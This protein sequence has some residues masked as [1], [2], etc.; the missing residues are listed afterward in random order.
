MPSA[1]TENGGPSF[2][3][4]NEYVRSRGGSL[5]HFLRSLLTVPAYWIVIASNVA[6]FFLPGMNLKEKATTLIWI[7]LGQSIMIGIVH[8][9][10]LFTYRF[11]PFTGKPGEWSSPKALGAF[12]LA[13]FG[14]FHFVYAMFIPFKR[15]DMMLFTE[16]LAIFGLSLFIN[17]IRHFPKENSG[18]YNANDFMFLPYFRIIP[19]HIAIILGGMVSIFSG[20]NAGVFVI[21]AILKT[22]MEMGMEYAQHLGVSLADINNFTEAKNMKSIVKPQKGKLLI[23]EP[24]LPDPNFSRSVVFLTEHNDEGSIGLVLDQKSG[25]RVNELFEELECDNAVYFGGPVA[26]DKLLFL[27]AFPGIPDSKEVLPGIFWGG[28]FEMLKFQLNEKL[29]DPAFVKFIV[30]YSGWAPGQLQDEM[31]QKSWIL[32]DSLFSDLFSDEDQLWKR[33]LLRQ[34]PEYAYLGNAPKDVRL[35]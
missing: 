21:L 22:V 12:F 31:N 9:L 10:K 4:L 20:G 33:V 15:I 8:A 24:F 35:N 34:G 27:H 18:N 14:F 16:G 23:S 11:S 17:T 5:S 30:G 3:T 32:A 26:R 19:I 29:I 28:D 25:M 13:H 1:N 6:I 2:S 7:Y